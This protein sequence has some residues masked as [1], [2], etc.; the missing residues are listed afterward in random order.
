MKIAAKSFFGAVIEELNKYTVKDKKYKINASPI[1][2]SKFGPSGSL[3]NKKS[4]LEHARDITPRIRNE[5]FFDVKYVLT[6]LLVLR[7]V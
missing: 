1:T 7:L 2:T 3:N 6:I 5:V 4:N